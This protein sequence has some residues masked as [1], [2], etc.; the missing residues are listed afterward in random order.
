PVSAENFNNG[1]PVRSPVMRTP[2]RLVAPSRPTS[3]SFS[4]TPAGQRVWSQWMYRAIGFA[5]SISIRI[6]AQTFRT[7]HLVGRIVEPEL[8]SEAEQARAYAGA[9]F[10]AAHSRYPL[11]FRERFPDCPPSG[12]A[13][14]LGC[15]P[16]DVTRRFAR[17]LPGWRFDAVD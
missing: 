14:D 15:G 8:M 2:G 3:G 7:I 4:T 10:E 12:H 6:V 9:N 17:A 11:L 13:L 1:M 5:T 16:G